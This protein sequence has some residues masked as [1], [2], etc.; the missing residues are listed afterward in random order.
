MGQT[1]NV[2]ITVLAVTM[3]AWTLQSI[4][5]AVQTTND[6]GITAGIAAIGGAAGYITLGAGGIGRYVLAMSGLGRYLFTQNRQDR[7]AV[8]LF[9]RWLPRLRKYAGKS[10]S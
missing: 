10:S 7:E 9:C 4:L 1:R 3:D 8:E 5:F 2:K 6:P